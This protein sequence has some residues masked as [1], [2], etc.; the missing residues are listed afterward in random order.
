MAVKCGGTAV[1]ICQ[2][3]EVRHSNNKLGTGNT[4]G[5]GAETTCFNVKEDVQVAKRP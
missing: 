2:W 4:G 1:E 3:P 5:R